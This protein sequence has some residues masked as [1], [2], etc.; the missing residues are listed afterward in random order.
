MLCMLGSTLGMLMESKLN[1][2][3]IN[4]FHAISDM[5]AMN[6]YLSHVKTFSTILIFSLY[7][8]IAWFIDTL[9]VS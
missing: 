2:F 5:E 8:E 7:L 3:T 6:C 4:R 1:S 9:A